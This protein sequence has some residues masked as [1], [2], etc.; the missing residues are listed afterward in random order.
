MKNLIISVV[1]VSIIMGSMNGIEYL[2]YNHNEETMA[3]FGFMTR[4]VIPPLL[5]LSVWGYLNKI[6]G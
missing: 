1:V 6:K 4:F 3:V 5:V 2:V